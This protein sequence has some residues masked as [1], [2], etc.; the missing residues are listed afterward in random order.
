MRFVAVKSVARQAGLTS[1]TRDLLARQ[2]TQTISALR[3]HLADYGIVAPQGPAHLP[4]L[5]AA[6][7]EAED[8]PPAVAELGVEPLSHIKALGG[9]I[10]EA[11][12]RA[13]EPRRTAARRPGA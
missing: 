4:R 6:L 2:R 11:R 5:E 13:S 12:T 9:R 7:T 8:L 1:K 3:G 10:D